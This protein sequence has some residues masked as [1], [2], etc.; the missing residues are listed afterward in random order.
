MCLSLHFVNALLTSKLVAPNHNIG[1]V[2]EGE[3]SVRANV[4]ALCPTVGT[5]KVRDSVQKSLMCNNAGSPGAPCINH[6][7]AGVHG[8]AQT[9]NHQP[10]SNVEFKEV[11]FPETYT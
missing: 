2:E 8:S 6:R 3:C 11:T 9:K 5:N 1:C 7:M 4:Y 10:S